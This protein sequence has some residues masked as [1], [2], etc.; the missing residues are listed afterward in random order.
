MDW[1]PSIHSLD[2]PDAQARWRT[3][4]E[5]SPQRSPFSSLTYIQAATEAF[6]LQTEMHLVASPEQ[7]EAGALVFWRKRGPYRQ[8]ALPPFTLFTPLVLRE[9]PAEAD[10]HAH[11]TALDVLLPSLEKRF[12][13]LRFFVPNLPD[14]RTARWQGWKPKP[15]YT[16]LIPLEGVKNFLHN[17]S[18]SHRRTFRKNRAA[19]TFAEAHDAASLVQLCSQSYARHDRRL[20]AERDRLTTLVEHLQAASSCRLFVVYPLGEDTPEAGVAM[21][22]DGKTACYWIAGS[23]P[24]PAMTVLLGHLL[25]LLRDE[26]FL[27]FDFVGANTASIAEFKRKFGAMLTPYWMLEKITRP[28]LRLYYSLKGA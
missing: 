23:E 14:I 17:W 7:D 20:P 3:L 15:F 16:Y 6:D 1:T 8:V 5:G 9:Q 4:W 21:L 13:V 28:E 12:D 2:D 10:I 27:S 19:Y 18:G 26:G 24:G 11:R 25:P 22:H